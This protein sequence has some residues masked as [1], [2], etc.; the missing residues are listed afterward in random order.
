MAPLCN[1]YYLNDI[2]ILLLFRKAVNIEIKEAQTFEVFF[3]SR[4]SF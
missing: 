4:L 3:L 2:T 1:D